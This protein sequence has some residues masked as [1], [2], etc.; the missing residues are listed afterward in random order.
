MSD[1][2]IKV[3]ATTNQPINVN[4][5]NTVAQYNVSA[6]T[7]KPIK[8]NVNGTVSQGSATTST[9]TSAYNANIAEQW[10]TSEG[11][12]LGKDYSSKY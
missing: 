6:T 3:K 10:A 7:N 11:L 2:S 8:V 1:N 12:V 9:D 5:S 4:V